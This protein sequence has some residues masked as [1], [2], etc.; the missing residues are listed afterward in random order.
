MRD[1]VIF[2]L[3]MVSGIAAFV[4][5]MVWLINFIVHGDSKSNVKS[6]KSEIENVV[7]RSS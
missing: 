1:D 3:R 2:G 5:G 4:F 7:Q 6:A